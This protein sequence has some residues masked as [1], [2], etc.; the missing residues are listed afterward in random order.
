MPVLPRQQRVVA[1]VGGTNTRIAIYDPD[2]GLRQVSRFLNRDYHRFQ[3][4]LA[5]WL[6]DLAEAPPSHACLA[7]AAP[8]DGD[9]VVMLNNDWS[10]SC[11][12]L[13]SQFGFTQLACINDFEANAY[14]LP[15]LTEAE[16][17]PL[18]T[19][20]GKPGSLA[21]LGPGT[22]LGG[23]TLDAAGARACEP[24]HMGLSPA[25]ELEL[26][27]FRQLLRQHDD[28]YAELLVSGPG[29]QRLYQTLGL[30]CGQAT[31]PLD[32][33]EISSRAQAGEDPLCVQ[34]LAIFCALLGS[35]SGDFVLATGAY[36]GLYLAGGIVPRILPFLRQSDFL[37][38]FRAKGGMSAH[39]E[40]VDIFAITTA[41]PGL[42][43]AAHAPLA[44][45]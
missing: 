38:R 40:A 14:A 10:F 8:P 30:V 32:A 27:I 41:Y 45:N 44:H 15:H 3:D 18:Q 29:L 5:Q 9:T 6:T 42:T 23:A 21:T 13:A 7:V 12:E 25:T 26:A 16:R 22:G 4:V 34:A 11:R 2:C 19:G 28:V 20:A 43:G 39:L 17:T 31:D 1:D 24:G 35:V 37:Q 36:K 33:A